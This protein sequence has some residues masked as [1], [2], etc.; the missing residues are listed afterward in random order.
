MSV[1]VQQSL[2]DELTELSYMFR[3][4]AAFHH[5]L[6]DVKRLPVHKLHD[7]PQMTSIDVT[8][9]TT[10]TTTAADA[11]T[12]SPS[13]GLGAAQTPVSRSLIGRAAPFLFTALGLTGAGGLGLA[14]AALLNKSQSV[15]EQTPQAKDGYLLQELQNRGLHLPEGAP[16][17]VK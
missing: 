7:D 14:A 8:T 12:N 10:D 2:M 15:T 9:S 6:P 11:A 17:Q 4:N 13:P 3:Q 16:W 5:G 1:A